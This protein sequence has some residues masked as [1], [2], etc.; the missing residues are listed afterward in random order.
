MAWF[1]GTGWFWFTMF[2]VALLVNGRAAFKL[3]L[4]WKGML[5]TCRFV[6]RAYDKVAALPDELTN[7]A[8]RT[9]TFL[10]TQSARVSIRNVESSSSGL[11]MQVLVENLSGHKLP[12]AYPSRRAWL[13]VTI[14][15]GNGRTVFESGALNPD[16]SIK[17]NDNDIDPL[18]FEPHYQEITSPE[19]VE[20]YEPILKD[21]AGR[22]TTGY[23]ARSSGLPRYDARLVTAVK[24]WQFEPFISDGKPLPVCSTVVF[25]YRQ[26]R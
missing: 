22:V 19:Q 5:T 14:R 17:G 18:R 16:A 7:A 13:H 8:A 23:L 24:Q 25:I 15:D 6:E 4:D 12:T 3:L 20:I 1:W 9:V 10:Q 2:W 26:Y 11:T 21:S